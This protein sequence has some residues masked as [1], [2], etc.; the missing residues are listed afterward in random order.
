MQQNASLQKFDSTVLAMQNHVWGDRLVF[1]FGWREDFIQTYTGDPV[2]DDRGLFPLARNLPLIKNQEGTLRPSSKGVVFHAF[3]WLSF[4]YSESNNFS[5]LAAV[6]HDFYRRNLPATSGEGE[7]YGIRLQLFGDKLSVNFN[8]YEIAQSNS[9][10]NADAAREINQFWELLGRFDELVDP[11][12][13]TKDTFDTSA[14]GWESTIV[15][16]PTPNWRL[17]GTVSRG[18]AGQS[19]V[20]PNSV[21][22]IATHLPAWQ[23][24]PAG[25][26]I[27][28]GRTVEDALR[29]MREQLTIRRAQ[30]GTQEYN[31]RKWNASFAT[32]YTFT[33]GFLKDVFVGGNALYRGDATIGYPLVNEEPVKEEPY[34]QKGY[35][36]VTLNFGYQRRLRE[37]YVWRTQVAIQN[38]FDYDGRILVASRHADGL[39][40]PAGTRWIPGTS[41]VLTTGVKF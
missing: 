10:G 11:W 18:Y 16:N 6:Q 37:R 12:P 28:D 13:A 27:A 35:T 39:P 15:Y 41:A 30:E 1:T 40:N 7:D 33:R 24:I 19:N 36:T 17:Y 38:A 34:I 25:T 21:S 5:G 23:A 2:A 3:P 8:K 4:H 31:M 14:R 29:R 22:Y 20:Y 32:N 26:T 9:F